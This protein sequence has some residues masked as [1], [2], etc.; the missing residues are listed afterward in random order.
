MKLAKPQF[1]IK[2]V[3]KKFKFILTHEKETFWLT[4]NSEINLKL[5]NLISLNGGS[6]KNYNHA[7]FLRKQLLEMILKVETTH[8]KY[9]KWLKKIY[10]N[11]YVY[12]WKEHWK[13]HRYCLTT[14]LKIFQTEKTWMKEKN[15][16]MKNV[17]KVKFHPEAIEIWNKSQE[18][19]YGRRK[20]FAR[21]N[22]S[23]LNLCS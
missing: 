17:I 20:N 6:Q 1:P 10:L 9:L 23:I 13:K 7:R 2:F 4:K 14:L 3:S 22:V 21:K 12:V 18:M 15:L 11:I 5:L 16:L 19:F 8:N